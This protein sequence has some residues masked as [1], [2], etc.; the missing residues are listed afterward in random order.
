MSEAEETAAIRAAV[1]KN[2]S[3][4]RIW[5]SKELV[6]QVMSAELV[7]QMLRHL[8]PKV[9][10]YLEKLVKGFKVEEGSIPLDSIQC[11]VCALFK[12]V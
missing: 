11:E 5:K 9:I 1:R 12:S 6:K 3:D 4:K 2:Q 8:S 7:H 10:K